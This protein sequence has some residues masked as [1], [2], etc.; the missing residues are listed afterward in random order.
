MKSYRTNNFRVARQLQQANIDTLLHRDSKSLIKIVNLS[1]LA[2]GY[3]DDK[4]SR[5]AGWDRTNN[6]GR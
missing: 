3:F 5:R 1:I 4:C 2:V 6:P